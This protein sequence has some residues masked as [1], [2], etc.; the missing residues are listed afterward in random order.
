M[1][2]T[3]K[4]HFFVCIAFLARVQT[5]AMVLHKA[6]SFP[7]KGTFVLFRSHILGF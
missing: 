2:A 3:R 6:S 1:G 4:F 5:V 7:K